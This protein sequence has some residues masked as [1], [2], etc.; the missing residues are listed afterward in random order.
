MTAPIVE[1]S[2][3]QCVVRFAGVSAR[4][5]WRAIVVVVTLLA[6]T[7]IVAVLAVGIG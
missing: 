3:R 6:G 4:A 2:R 7:F 1:S 5:S